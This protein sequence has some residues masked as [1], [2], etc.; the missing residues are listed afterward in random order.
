MKQETIDKL[1][2]LEGRLV[3]AER[4][5]GWFEGWGEELYR[6]DDTPEVPD[7]FDLVIR[8]NMCKC[9]LQ[10]EMSRDVVETMYNVA[11]EQARNE[12]ELIKMEIENL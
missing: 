3:E 5:I 2:E 4:A 1:H 12:V 11:L 7:K 6:P 10:R 8:R 9:V